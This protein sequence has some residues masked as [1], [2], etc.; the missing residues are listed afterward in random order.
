MKRKIV[1]IDEEKCNGCGACIPNCAEGAIKIIDGK[2]K[3]LDDKFCD[4]LG[5]CLGHCPQDAIIVIERDAPEFDEEAVK[6]HLNTAEE[7]P[8]SINKGIPC[9]TMHGGPRSCP[10]SMAMD[11]K[12]KRNTNA[13]ASQRQKPELRQWP[14]QLTLVS[15]QASYFKDADL[16]VAADCVPFAYPNFHS[17]FLSGKS[18]VIGCPKLDDA[19]YY[20]DKLTELIRAGNIKTITLV[21]MEVPCCFGLQRIVEEAVKKSGKVLPIRQTVI[22]VKGEKQ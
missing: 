13:G 19:D 16:L 7:K 2:A 9:G 12:S 6:I 5:A 10:G 14:V 4:G 22:T 15:P 1:S 3:L 18:I 20:I 21:N 8:E 17:D 11:F